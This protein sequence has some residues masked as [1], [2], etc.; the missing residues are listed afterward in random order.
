[1]P[2]PLKNAC[3]ESGPDERKIRNSGK[4]KNFVLIKIFEA[5]R[6]YIRNASGS[7]T[8]NANRPTLFF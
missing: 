5:G 2:I 3:A 1:M 7:R 6:I 4:T 8:K